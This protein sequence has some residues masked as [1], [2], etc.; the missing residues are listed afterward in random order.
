MNTDSA[1]P[2]S[3]HMSIFRLSDVPPAPECTVARA[4]A[5]RGTAWHETVKVLFL[6]AKLAFHH[7]PTVKPC[8]LFKN[9]GVAAFAALLRRVWTKTRLAEPNT[10]LTAPFLTFSECQVGTSTDDQGRAKSRAPG[11]RS[12][13][14]PALPFSRLWTTDI[15]P[16]LASFQT[17]KPSGSD[18]PQTLR[19]A[20]AAGF[21]HS[22][23]FILCA[24]SLLLAASPAC[25]DWNRLDARS[26]G[27]RSGADHVWADEPS[28]SPV[29]IEALPVDHDAETIAELGDMIGGAVSGAHGYDAVN[30]A[31]HI[32]LTVPLPRPLTAMTLAEI[33]TWIDESPDQSHAV[34][35]FQITAKTLRETQARLSLSGD[36]VF[37]AETQD[38]MA[39]LLYRDAGLDDYLGGRIS[40]DQFMDQLAII[41]PELPGLNGL[42][43]YHGQTDHR[44]TVTRTHYAETMRTIF[45]LKN[46]ESAWETAVFRL[47]PRSAPGVRFVHP[48]LLSGLGDLVSKAESPR[49]GY[50]AVIRPRAG[51]R[52]VSPPMKPTLMTLGQIH[53]WVDATPNQDHAIG[54]YQIIPKT[55]RH[56]Q[57]RLG[58]PNTHRFDAATQDKMARL[59]YEDAGLLTYLDGTITLDRFM[60]RL[61][62]IWAGLPL[63]NGRSVYQGFN[64]NKATLSRS[65]FDA[66]MRALFVQAHDNAS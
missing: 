62:V 27:W 8:F 40:L 41:W 23:A 49:D 19:F 51:K 65:V 5:R 43:L 46:N 47:V 4:V 21:S 31:P 48:R 60:D 3:K 12:F 1:H 9:S 55:F 37:D 54:K 52:F 42:S 29:A 10:H 45:A 32:A 6:G 50:D 7:E 2:D 30:A 11:G 24:A 64:G 14:A 35:K 36:Q 16:G 61:A 58:L 34:G 22:A 26:D 28:D 57:R 17:V 63:R 15:A 39:H 18:D 53:A 44:A 25:A 20:V 38:R 33:Q 66:E 59:L 13:A 56:L